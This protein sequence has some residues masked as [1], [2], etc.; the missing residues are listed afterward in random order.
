VT[1]EK[2]RWVFVLAFGLLLAGGLL[3]EVGGQGTFSIQAP[4]TEEEE[5][6]TFTLEEV[7]QLLVANGVLEETA[8]AQLARFPADRT[9]T[10]AEIELL[11]QVLRPEEAPIVPGQPS[12]LPKPGTLGRPPAPKIQPPIQKEIVPEGY[13]ERMLKPFGYDLFRN[14]T[15]AAAP[16]IDVAVGPEYVLGVGDQILVT[17]WGDIDQRYARLVDRQG[18]LI[19]PDVGAVTAAGRSLGE[20]REELQALYARVYRNFQMAVSLGEVRTIPVYVSGDVLR[21]GGYTL[22]ALATAFAAL[23]EAGGPTLKGSLRSITLSRR[24]QAMRE[25]D[26][27]GF[28][29]SGDRGLDTPIQSSDVVHVHPLGPTVKIYGEIRRPAIYEI[30]EGEKLRDAIRMAGGLTPLAL[31]HRVTVDRLSETQGVQ[32]FQVDWADSTQDLSLRG[33]DEI[34]VFSVFQARPKEFVEIRGLVQYPGIYRLVPGMKVGDLVFRAGGPLEGAY[35]EHAEIARQVESEHAD[36]LAKT[37]LISFPL[38]EVLQAPE[39]AENWELR[40]GDK[41]FVRAAPGW[42]PPPVVT[43]Q[44]EVRI[45]GKYGLKNLSERISDLVGRA[46]GLTVDAFPRGAKVFRQKTGR[47]VIDLSKAVSNPQSGDNIAL[48]DGDSVYVPRQPETVKVS[49]AVG[50]PGLLV[51]VPGKNADYYI[52][53]TGGLTEKANSH[54]IKIIRVTGDAVSAHRSLWRDPVVQEGD[55]V[56]VEV[57]EESKPVDWGKTLREAATI[58]ASLATTVY[59]ISNLNK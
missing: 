40:R 5:A 47:I 37:I 41:V 48:A 25:I 49:G 14:A 36:S 45:P 28:L 15:P 39:H 7:R 16:P 56:R 23:Y 17:I 46:G 6:P 58:I 31:T 38:S 2:W 20:L 10:Q 12:T 51:Y 34:T 43:L 22:S 13:E 11:L 59:V 53:R 35:L 32:V 55:E 54:R 9:F 19:L 21:P 52:E 24:G 3:S 29:L 33:G 50:I 1:S 18:R 4:A 42:V 30:R 8:D 26:L 57:R 44:G 27:Y